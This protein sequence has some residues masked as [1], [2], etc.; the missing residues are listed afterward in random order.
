MGLAN[1]WDAHIV[2]RIIRCACGLPMI[3]ELRGEVVPLA[4]GRVFELGCGG[5][6]NQPF[7]NAAQITALSGLDPSAKLLDFAR[8]EARAKGWEADIRAGFGEDLPF[9]D[10][11]FDTVVSTFTLCS[12]S[13]HAKVLSELRRVL[14]PG[15]T[16]LY[17]EHG[18][19]PD[20]GVSRWQ[21]RIE[22]V[23][24][25]LTGNCHLTRKVSSAIAESG[26][27]VSQIGGR[28]VKGT[29]RPMGWIEWG[30]ATKAA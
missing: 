26:F 9:D 25:H 16:M 22:P 11:S 20:A 27:A 2:P 8:E 1:W 12:V 6:L 10:A 13:D 15:G 5:G 29:P 17:V 24:K 4:K 7:Y 21:R 28:F 3:A 19:A 30:W 18:S 23:W 14:K